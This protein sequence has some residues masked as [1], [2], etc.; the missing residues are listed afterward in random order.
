MRRGVVGGALTK[1]RFLALTTKCWME[2]MKE[3][4]W[5]GAVRNWEARVGKLFIII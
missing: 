5:K 1:D 2:G 4:R 3:G